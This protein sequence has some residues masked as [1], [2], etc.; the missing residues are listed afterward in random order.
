M[1]K[2]T[3]FFFGHAKNIVPLCAIFSNVSLAV[4]QY[5][6]PI[7]WIRKQTPLE[8]PEQGRLLSDC[9]KTVMIIDKKMT[10]NDLR[11][12]PYVN[13]AN[14]VS[15]FLPV[16]LSLALFIWNTPNTHST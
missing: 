4:E 15:F 9:C 10:T 12:S 1:S 11:R 13:C 2:N 7:A 14:I 6:S 16:I 8:P 5:T 3:F